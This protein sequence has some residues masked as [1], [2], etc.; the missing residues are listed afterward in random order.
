MAA[1]NELP[2]KPTTVEHK[3]NANAGNEDIAQLCEGAEHWDWDDM[4]SDF[5]TT[6]ISS[7]SRDVA[8]PSL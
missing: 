5:M 3:R 8:L 6:E 2:V 7:A 1:F 4:N